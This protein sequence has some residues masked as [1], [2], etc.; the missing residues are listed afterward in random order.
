MKIIQILIRTYRVID[1]S[2]LNK[3]I[4]SLEGYMILKLETG[5]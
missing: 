4:D 2:Q 1:I 3:L 5:E